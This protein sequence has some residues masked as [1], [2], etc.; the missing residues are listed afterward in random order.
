M[1]CAVAVACVLSVDCTIAGLCSTGTSAVG[2]TAASSQKQQI[3]RTT[4]PHT[5]PQQPSRFL[6]QPLS[7]VVQYSYAMTVFRLRT[8]T[9]NPSTLPAPARQHQQCPI[10]A[11][12]VSQALRNEDDYQKFASDD[13]RAH[14]TVGGGSDLLRTMFSM[15]AACA[16]RGYGRVLLSCRCKQLEKEPSS[17]RQASHRIA[18]AHSLLQQRQLSNW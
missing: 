8:S 12:H 13:S 16:R 14:V 9:P 7:S 6:S 10:A 4:Y 11:L 3:T 15:A 5:H 18:A 1:L 2:E 17:C